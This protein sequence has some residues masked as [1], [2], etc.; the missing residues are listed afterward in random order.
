MKNKTDNSLPSSTEVKNAWN[1]T[2]TPQGVS[3]ARC[4]STGAPLPVIQCKSDLL[5]SVCCS[6]VCVTTLCLLYRLSGALSLG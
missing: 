1:F 3:I 6:L 4:L 5:A 2:S